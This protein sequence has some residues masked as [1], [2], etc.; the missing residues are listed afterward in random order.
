L[1]ANKDGAIIINKGYRIVPLTGKIDP[2]VN[3]PQRWKSSILENRIRQRPAPANPIQVAAVEK[4]WEFPA[5]A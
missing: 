1:A 2:V 4:A 3:V 5:R